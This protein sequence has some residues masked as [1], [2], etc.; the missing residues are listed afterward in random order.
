MSNNKTQPHSKLKLVAFGAS[1]LPNSSDVINLVS[2]DSA[3]LDKINKLKTQ[4]QCVGVYDQLY[5]DKLKVHHVGPYTTH[6]QCK[7]SAKQLEKLLGGL[8]AY[9]GDSCVRLCEESRER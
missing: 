8:Q 3:I 2:N 4:P 1:I 7:L 9:Y 5:S 6:E